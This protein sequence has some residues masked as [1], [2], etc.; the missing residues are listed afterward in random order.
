MLPQ[1]IP[2]AEWLNAGGH[3]QA[4]F[5]KKL[6]DL[7]KWINKQQFKLERLEHV[8]ETLSIMLEESVQEL[9]KKSWD[10]AQANQSLV[11]A[12]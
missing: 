3:D 8:K 10:L 11:M 7:E 6:A 5:M 1:L 2:I 12:I 9:E 4:D